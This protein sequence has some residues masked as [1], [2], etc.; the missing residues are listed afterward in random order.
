M[1]L[2]KGR[3]SKQATSSANRFNASIEVDQR[4]YRQDILGSI[5]HGKMLAHQ[6]IISD[7]ERDA[8]IRGLNEILQEYE[9]G[10]IQ[11]TVENED[12][13]MG[14]ES[15]L[16]EKIGDAGKKLHTARSRNDQVATDLRLYLKE[17]ID[18]T[19]KLID[20]LIQLIDKLMIEHE[21]T[22]LPGYTHMQ[23]AQPVT[24]AWHLS[25]YRE[26]FLRDKERFLDG[27]KRTDSMPLGACA[28]AGTSYNIDREFVKAELGFS[29]I[30]HSTMDAVSD[31]D[32]ALEFIFCVCV[33]MMHLS[34]FCE[35]IVY[36]N[37]KEFDFI[38]ID[39]AYSTGSSIMPQKK[40]PDMAELI[41][42]KTGR[43][44]GDLMALLTVMKG[45]PLAY[46][47]DMQEDKEP[48]FD[49]GD[50]LRDSLEIFTEM[51][52]T[53]EFKKE[54]ME[55]AA[56]KGFMNATDAADYLVKKGVPFRDCH[57]IIGSMVLG[58]IECGKT[59]EELEL[60]ELK[61]YSDLFDSD[62]YD[63]IELKTLIEA[64]KR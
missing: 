24:L 48:V 4:M 64:R 36:W 25:A 40:N 17:E 46:N 38:E 26:M 27:Y 20:G 8:I 5:A 28:L 50:T 30:C 53:I 15:L 43:V 49:A 7:A 59:I 62:I 29:D 39:D 34:R 31:R 55:E 13:H 33:T 1:K 32:F 14:I 44:Y 3:F 16:T 63:A 56:K 19:V 41:R 60:E 42:G 52:A 61:K 9:A 57:E 35:E 12:I 2:W 23:R 6:G 22:I 11:F 45:L 10:S 18:E 21:N 37:S 54:N 58:C 47:K 51:L